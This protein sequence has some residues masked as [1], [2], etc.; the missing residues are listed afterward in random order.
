[1]SQPGK[2]SFSG[3]FLVYINGVRVPALSASV[4]VQIDSPASAT[5]QLPA[6]SILFG[7]GDEDLLDVAVF[8]LD[9]H[10]R[11]TP[12]W[13]LLYEGRVIGQGYSNE[14]SSESMYISVESNMNALADLYLNFMPKGNGK[15]TSSS[16]YPNQINIK[17]KSSKRFLSESLSGRKLA[18]P[19]DLIDNVYYSVL[20]STAAGV[21]SRLSKLATK[22]VESIVAKKK[23][24]LGNKFEREAKKRL[25]ANAI[26]ASDVNYSTLLSDEIA[27]L[28]Q[29]WVESRK[30]DSVTSSLDVEIKNI[31]KKEIKAS[32]QK[33]SPTVITGFFARYFRKIRSRNHW[34]CSPYIEGVPNSDN[35]IKALIG[36]GVF[37][38]FRASKAARYAK[39]MVRQS[40]AKYGPGG[41]ALALVKSIFGLYFYKV[42]EVL[43]PPVYTADKYGLPNNTFYS[44]SGGSASE[45]EK[46][47][48]YYT[49]WSSALTSKKNRLC[50][51]SYLTHP[52]LTFCVPPACNVVFPSTRV[53]LNI[54]NNYKSKPTRLYYDKRSPYGRLDFSVNS[55]SYATESS[56]VTFPSVVAGAAQKAAGKASEQIDLLVFPEEYYRGP[57]PTPGQMHPT[58]LDLKKYA[59]SARFGTEDRGDPVIAVPSVEGMSPE[60]AISALESVEKATSK[61]ISSYGLYYMLAR[62][63]FL[64]RKYGAVTGDVGMLF[65]PYLVCGFP[66]AVLSGDKSG[67]HFYGE[68]ASISHSLTASSSSTSIQLGTVRSLSDIIQGISADGFDLDSYPQEPIQEIRDLLQVFESSNEYYNQVFH[69][70]NIGSLSSKEFASV[71]EY[72]KVSEELEQIQDQI[73]KIEDAQNMGDE[74]Y[75]SD[76]LEELLKSKSTL[77]NAL[78]KLPSSIEYDDILSS[79]RDLPAAFDFKSF[80]GWETEPGAD[81]DY[82]VINRLDEERRQGQENRISSTGFRRAKLVP[83]PE[84]S[85]YFKSSSAAL[86]LS[87]R[88]VC[89]LEQYIDFYACVDV[90]KAISDNEGRGRGCRL[91]ERRDHFSGAVYYDVI[92]QYI[93]GPGMEPGTTIAGRSKDLSARLNY[94]V[95]K[96]PNSLDEEQIENLKEKIGFLD[97]S[98]LE[99]TGL[100]PNGPK[101]FAKLSTND[102]ITFSDL[103]DSR[104]DWQRLLLDY[105]TIIEGKAPQI[106]EG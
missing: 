65:N 41:S 86:R 53:S 71:Q 82:I 99:L 105:L 34:A 9:T 62:Q 56:R 61:K 55:S 90:D 60:E 96:N 98:D 91:G 5:I 92:R 72:K 39:S 29:L 100:G 15:V 18:R 37:P 21:E 19:F 63:E 64:K 75:M 103:P 27:K 48:S 22:S 85:E 51:A 101:V 88:P 52:S 46:G 54:N 20:G 11:D 87:S 32:A 45:S 94:L 38:M 84:T 74:S 106:A 43:A 59:S 6:H 16:S 35:P 78:S 3:G 7:L 40:G 67:L 8:Y 23:A 47:Q 24:A 25:A 17:G 93:G 68:I 66:C 70:D 102:T 73:D 14:P 89:T 77:E 79:Q 2:E 44:E 97:S 31:L 33:G 28:E 69:K 13:C 58:Y 10:Y 12:T 49:S 4:N 83:L 81:P 26:K 36:G 30:G 50:M 57:V 104:K 76:T 95:N 1:M 80:L 42:S